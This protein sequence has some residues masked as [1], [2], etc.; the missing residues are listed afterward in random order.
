M[1]KWKILCNDELRF[2]P[3]A[4]KVLHEIA[5]VDYVEPKY[6]ILLDCIE[7]YDAYFASAHI[8][9]DPKVL[10]RAKR[11]KVIATPST[12]TDHIDVKFAKTKG[13]EV[14]DIAKDYD[15]LDTFSATAE[16]AFCLLLSLTRRLP[17]AFEAAK[18]GYW[19]RQDFSGRQLL[20]KT[21]GILG[22]GRLGKMMADI[23][24]GFKMKIL[25]CDIRSFSAP[26]VKQ[27]DF[28]T[29]LSESDILSIHIHL[30]EANRGLISTETFSM[31]KQGIIIINTSRGAII[32]E[33]AFLD[34]L[35]SGKVSGAG[36]DV[37]HGEWES[38]L[39]EHPLIKYSQ[40]HDNLIITPH[41]GGSTVES[42]VGA[43]EFMAQK[44]ADYIKATIK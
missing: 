16:M 5:D 27:V 31:M 28:S 33:E 23:G 41:I 19:A 2:K 38:N 32:N 22:Y 11:L 25:A 26:G 6:D 29:L 4:L 36:L 30:N 13:I 39:S 42:I 21:L 10:D 40:E 14:L 44:L 24:K 7:K 15:L 43:R 3:D 35:E 12:G 34:A 37:I 9:A 1:N 17:W 20:G 8:R 18:K